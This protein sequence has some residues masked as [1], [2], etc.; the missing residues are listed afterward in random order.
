MHEAEADG[1]TYDHEL[2]MGLEDL[3]PETLDGIET[4]AEPLAFLKKISYEGKE[5][6][7]S[8]LIATLN[9]SKSKKV[10]WCT[11]HVHNVAIDDLYNSKQQE[12]GFFTGTGIPTVIGSWVPWVR[13]RCGIWH[14]ATYYV[15]VLQCYGYVTGILPPGEHKFYGFETHFFLNLIIFFHP[16]TP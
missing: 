2:G 3:L 7:K 4:D 16:V 5:I 15:P 11:W 14:T 1:D 8:S 12:I 10:P 6:L 9:N 13:V